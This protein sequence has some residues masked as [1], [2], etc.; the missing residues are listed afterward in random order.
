V[1]PMMKHIFNKCSWTVLLPVGI[2]FLLL[3]VN[4][5]FAA[6]SGHVASF[7]NEDNAAKFVARMKAKGL[8]AFYKKADVQQKGELYRSYIG[9]YKTRLQARKALAKL[10]KAGVIDYFQIQK[11]AAQDGKIVMKKM[12]TKPQKDKPALQKSVKSKETIIPAAREKQGGEILKA[13]AYEMKKP[14]TMKPDLKA[15]GHF[16]LGME[17]ITKRQYEAAL[18][19]L[20]KAISE[21]DGFAAAYNKRCFVLHMIGNT[22][23]AIKDCTKAIILKPDFAEAYYN[24]GLANQAANQIESAV[25]DYGRAIAIDSNYEAAYTKR[26]YMYYLAGHSKQAIDYYTK[27]IGIKPD[28]D[29]AYF[30]RA[31][32]YHDSGNMDNALADVQKACLLKNEQACR[33]AEDMSRK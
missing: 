31:L 22:D 4:P 10:K 13:P 12:K 19:D 14:Q 20:N 27:A 26:G 7:K 18:D 21:D 2:L 9:K 5:L 16:N 17:N 30:N 29:E 24:R 23:S 28:D 32:A 1:S 8:V 6:Y 15:M 33:I 25:A 11:T 3:S